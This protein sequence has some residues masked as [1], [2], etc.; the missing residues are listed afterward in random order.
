M[1]QRNTLRAASHMN[2]RF[3]RTNRLVILFLRF[4]FGPIAL[5]FGCEWLQDVAQIDH[6]VAN[7]GGFSES[8]RCRNVTK[9]A[10]DYGEFLIS[11]C[12][13]RFH[14][15][16]ELLLCETEILGTFHAASDERHREYFKGGRKDDNVGVRYATHRRLFMSVM[17][18][19]N[20]L[21]VLACRVKSPHPKVHRAQGMI[22]VCDA[23]SARDGRRSEFKREKQNRWNY[24]SLRHGD[25]PPSY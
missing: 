22:E 8:W 13:E 14:D 7:I 10:V 12:D 20:L 3:L 23:L 16:A 25:K 4:G 19:L 11:G 24:H 17:V 1:K 2:T 9:I 18:I 6:G 5:L 15:R 21:Q